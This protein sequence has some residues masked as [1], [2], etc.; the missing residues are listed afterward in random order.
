MILVCDV[1]NTNIVF[2]VFDK[3]KL[4]LQFRISTFINRT[5]DEYAVIILPILR[6]N[7]IDK[8]DIEDIII[9]SVVPPLLFHIKNTFRKYFDII[10]FVLD[11]NH[12]LCIKNLY[13][14]PEHVGIDRLV[15]SVAGFYK[16]KSALIIIDFGT[17]T[18][19]DVVSSKGEYIGGIITPGIKIS[20][21]AL[22]LN[23]SKLPKVEIERPPS[24][25][26]K[27][28]VHSIQSGLTYGYSALVDGIVQKIKEEYNEENF[29]VIATG[30]LASIIDEIS[31]SIEVVERDLTLNGLNI[32]FNKRNKNEF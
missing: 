6:E 21:E 2:G 25:V 22:F 31:K 12:E 9:A 26:G 3:N 4:V 17:A 28:T 24:V 14:P 8:N 27:T 10:P 5:S 23:T 20:K 15:N 18:T 16:Y 30:G 32:I 7:N 13:N 11:S 29:K 19:F 1:G